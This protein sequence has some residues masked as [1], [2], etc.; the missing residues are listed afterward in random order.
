M[1]V[2]HAAAALYDRVNI[3]YSLTE[4]DKNKFSAE[5]ADT[6]GSE[7]FD[8]IIGSNKFIP[9]YENKTDSNLNTRSFEEQLIGAVAGESLSVTV[10]FPDDYVFQDEQGADSDDLAAAVCTFD[11]TVNSICRGEV[12]ELA[13]NLIANY[14]AEMYTTVA[15]YRDYIYNYYRSAFAY[16]AVMK[17]TTVKSY[18]EEE[19]YKARLNYMTSVIGSQYSASQL[20]DEDMQAL[21]DML[22]DQADAHAREAVF[23]RML[24]EYLFDKCDI[25]LS[26]TSY[27]SMLEDD[28][29]S[30]YYYYY[31]YYKVTTME[32]YESYF[33]K[34]NLVLQYKYQKMMDVLAGYVTV[35]PA[36]E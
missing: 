19:L 18:P 12:P 26:E 24:L 30:R 6:L 11:V 7:S 32:E 8:L 14:T 27:K 23:E 28:Y 9:A 36:D 35:V 5:V 1:P 20:D 34:E 13:A 16:D 21:Y 10:T 22:Y 25:T 31:M 15:A 2:D 29:R 4:E 17:A 33:G 3:K